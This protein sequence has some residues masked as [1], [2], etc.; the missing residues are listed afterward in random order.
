MYL[1]GGRG[2]A[3]LVLNG[4][5]STVGDHSLGYLLQTT[6]GQ[7]D[8]AS[9]TEMGVLVPYLVNKT[10][11]QLVSMDTSQAWLSKAALH[12]SWLTSYL[13]PLLNERQASSR[14]LKPCRRRSSLHAVLCKQQQRVLVTRLTSLS[15]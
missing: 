13:V 14:S 9:H 5:G 2:Q 15:T 1:A 3:D 4:S 11:L 6:V 8:L 10:F 7:G 12:L